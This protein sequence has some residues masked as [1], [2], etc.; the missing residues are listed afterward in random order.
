MFKFFGKL[1]RSL[2]LIAELREGQQRIEAR[3]D[4]ISERLTRLEAESRSFF[5]HK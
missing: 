2:A 1:I 3:L 4:D 5:F